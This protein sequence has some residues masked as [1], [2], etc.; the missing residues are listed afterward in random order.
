MLHPYQLAWLAK[1]RPLALAN[2]RR[3]G[4]PAL[5]TLA[6][7]LVESEW[8]LTKLGNN[9][10][11]IKAG[12]GWHGA[13]NMQ[14]T[15]ENMPDGR[16]YPTIDSFRGYATPADAYQGHATFL[17]LQPRYRAAFLT[18]NPVEFARAVADAHYATDPNYFEKL[19]KNIY[20]LSGKK[21]PPPE[22][23]QEVGGGV[24]GLLLLAGVGYWLTQRKQAR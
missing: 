14:R 21:M 5:F 13:A 17:R 10:F 6:Q 7:Q 8:K 20:W 19:R 16:E 4:V 15:H 11:G 22:V 18:T 2:E 23:A 12:P 9:F 3:Y 1:F 24:V